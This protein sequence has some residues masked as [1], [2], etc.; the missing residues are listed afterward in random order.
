MQKND[1]TAIVVVAQDPS[2]YFYVLDAW[3]SRKPPSEQ[4]A[5]A[6]RLHRKW[7]FGKLYLETVGF[8]ELLKD[9][10]TDYELASGQS[11]KVEG[12]KVHSNKQD[13]ISTLEPYFENG[14]VAFAEGI[15]RELLNQLRLFP[16]DHDD[17]PDAL[18]GAISR[19]KKPFGA[20]SV[21]NS[22]QELF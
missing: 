3:L 14:F 20:I 18:H 13:R 15:N 2:R 12:V 10:F 4:I 5:A 9:K 21:L 11:M 16:T 8:Q 22:G 6:F 7:G 1:F 17:G 19:L